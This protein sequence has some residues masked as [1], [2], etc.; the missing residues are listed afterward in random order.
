MAS[1]WQRWPVIRRRAR[2]LQQL[3]R[4]G[5]LAPL[6]GN[7]IGFLAGSQRAAALP[8]I[9]KIDIPPVCSLASS[10]CLHADPRDCNPLALTAQLFNRR[11]RMSLP[12]CR[13]VVDQL[14]G[15]AVAVSLFYHGDPI[16]DPDLDA[17]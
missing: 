6:A 12:Q 1:V 5:S 17:R 2:W 8:S 15:H 7:I 10:N 11:H 9:V 4:V 14:R 16:S 3:P 13:G